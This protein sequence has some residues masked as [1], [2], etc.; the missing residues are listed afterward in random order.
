[1]AFG[2]DYN[3]LISYPNLTSQYFTCIGC[4]TCSREE[5][6]NFGKIQRVWFSF[7]ELEEKVPEDFGFLWAGDQ[8]NINVL[9]L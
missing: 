8:L 7:A 3:S 5:E 6:G 4:E 9:Y 2:P 1:V